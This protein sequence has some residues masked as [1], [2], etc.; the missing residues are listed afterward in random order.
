MLRATDDNFM[1]VS[2]CVNR[3]CLVAWPAGRHATTMQE[4]SCWQR[5]L[6]C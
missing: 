5:R 6:T 2:T 3:N 1:L 4:R